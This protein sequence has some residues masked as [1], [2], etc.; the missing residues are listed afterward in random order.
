M[1]FRE[2]YVE[3]PLKLIVKGFKFQLDVAILKMYQISSL[4]TQL[5]KNSS[6]L[7]IW[8]LKFEM[9]NFQV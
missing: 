7:N 2:D 6:K 9:W 5:V 8:G 3:A 1:Y 4:K